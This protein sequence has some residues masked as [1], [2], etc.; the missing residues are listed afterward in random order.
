MV[1][2][3]VYRYLNYQEVD[4]VKHQLII[5]LATLARLREWT[6]SQ[7]ILYPRDIAVDTQLLL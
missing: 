4:I 2:A 1:D 5:D 7:D 6:K 3:K